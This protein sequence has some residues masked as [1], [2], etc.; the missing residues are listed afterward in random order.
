MSN[1]IGIKQP[2]NTLRPYYYYLKRTIKYPNINIYYISYN[3]SNFTPK[4]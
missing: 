1:I 3:P 2:S 4:L